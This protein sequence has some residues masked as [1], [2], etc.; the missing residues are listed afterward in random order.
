LAQ[1]YAMA[2]LCF[3]AGRIDDAVGYAAAGQEAIISGRLSRS[4]GCHRLERLSD[5]RAIEVGDPSYRTIKGILIAG[6][7]HGT[8]EPI[9]GS[10]GAAGRFC[11]ALTSSA[12]TSASS[13][14][15]HESQT[16]PTQSTP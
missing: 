3:T 2:T 5:A 13:P 9:T 8:D 14:D 16:I 10:A 12:P 7:E 4:S 11:A 15:L 6:T 1:L